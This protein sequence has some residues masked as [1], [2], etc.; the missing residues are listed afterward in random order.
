MNAELPKRVRHKTRGSTYEVLGIA[1]A[2]VSHPRGYTPLYDHDTMVVYRA[3]DGGKFWVRSFEEF[4]DGRFEEIP[5]ACVEE[6]LRTLSAERDEA[7][8]QRDQAREAL[9]DAMSKAA[10]IVAGL[11][12]RS[13]PPGNNYATG[14]NAAETALRREVARR[15]PLMLVGS[16]AIQGGEHDR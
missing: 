14:L 10:D 16:A 7:I 1:E 6:A 15:S 13:D 8:R 9:K 5:V 2:Q 4:M 12:R 11:P 3:E